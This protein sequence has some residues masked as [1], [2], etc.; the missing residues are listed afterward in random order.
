[1]EKETQLN[2][3][4]F[5]KYGTSIPRSAKVNRT[6]FST[7]EVLRSFNEKEK[8]HSRMMNE[9][10]KVHEHKRKLSSKKKDFAERMA[11][12]AKN[13]YNYNLNQN[14]PGL[15]SNPGGFRENLLQAAKHLYIVQNYDDISQR[16][17]ITKILEPQQLRAYQQQQKKPELEA[18]LRYANKCALAAQNAKDDHNFTLNQYNKNV[19]QAITKSKR[20]AAFIRSE[21][22][23]RWE[24]SISNAKW[25]EAKNLAQEALVDMREFVRGLDYNRKGDIVGMCYE[26]SLVELIYHCNAVQELTKAIRYMIKC[27]S[28]ISSKEEDPEEPKVEETEY[29]QPKISRSDVSYLDELTSVFNVSHGL[30]VAPNTEEHLNSAPKTKKAAH[31]NNNQR[32]GRVDSTQTKRR[33]SDVRD[34]GDSRIQRGYVKSSERPFPSTNPMKN[35]SC[36]TEMDEIS[37]KSDTTTTVTTTA[38]TEYSKSSSDTSSNSSIVKNEEIIQTID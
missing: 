25:Q 6:V 33:G 11:N 31:Q 10:L 2:V 12:F 22:S 14:I 13:E 15:N 20:P 37:Y 17:I 32:P 34:Q 29:T 7:T 38:I 9:L 19:N 3:S 5:M 24:E 21:G 1:M 23:A 35:K 27:L 28:C 8:L 30:P 26:Y 18:N 4:N 16:R 36:V